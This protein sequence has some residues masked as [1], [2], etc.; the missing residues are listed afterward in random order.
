MAPPDCLHGP[1]RLAAGFA[2][3]LQPALPVHRTWGSSLHT[4][5]APRAAAAAMSSEAKPKKGGKKKAPA[6]AAKEEE[7]VP[8]PPFKPAKLTHYDRQVVDYVRTATAKN[9]WYYRCAEGRAWGAGDA[10]MGAMAVR[11]SA[12]AAGAGRWRRSATSAA[13]AAAP[14]APA[15][16]HQHAARPHAPAAL[17]G[18][19]CRCARRPRRSA[20][21]TA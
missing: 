16:S 14:R 5:I 1:H 20:T 11:T 12:A 19:H 7:R 4:S 21:G 15:F 8:P 9:I 10:A 2:C 6:A 17:H 13:A 18:A 3:G